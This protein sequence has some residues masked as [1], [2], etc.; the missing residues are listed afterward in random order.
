MVVGGGSIVDD[1]TR[2]WVRDEEVMDERWND[3]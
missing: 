2:W 1:G 3:G